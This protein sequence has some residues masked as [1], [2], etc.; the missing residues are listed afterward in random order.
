MG[1]CICSLAGTRACLTCPNA[2]MGVGNPVTVTPVSE[3]GWICPACG[4]SNAPWVKTCTCWSGKITVW[5]AQPDTI[6][7]MWQTTCGERT[8]DEPV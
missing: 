3:T 2:P 8:G 5:P 1:F 7:P 4:R 6:G